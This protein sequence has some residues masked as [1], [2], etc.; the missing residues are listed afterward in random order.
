MTAKELFEQDKISPGRFYLDLNEAV[1]YDNEYK[2]ENTGEIV[3]S[4]YDSIKTNK[5]TV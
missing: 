1:Q 5:R 4:I 2:I 3:H